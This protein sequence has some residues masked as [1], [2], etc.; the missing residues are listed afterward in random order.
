MFAC[1][2]PF[3]FMKESWPSGRQEKVGSRTKHETSF[4][5][6]FLAL[7]TSLEIHGSRLDTENR[8]LFEGNLANLRKQII[9]LAAE[10][11]TFD[12][13]L[14]LDEGTAMKK[15]TSWMENIQRI[16]AVMS[17][18]KLKN[19]PL[20][21]E[22]KTWTQALEDIRQ[23]IVPLI[24]DWQAHKKINPVLTAAV[25]E[26]RQRFIP[27]VEQNLVQEKEH[28]VHFAKQ[29][30][31]GFWKQALLAGAL[32]LGGV[33]RNTDPHPRTAA[34]RDGGSEKPHSGTESL[35]EGNEQRQRQDPQREFLRRPRGRAGEPE[36]GDSGDRPGELREARTFGRI[37]LYQGH[38]INTSLWV[39]SYQHRQPEQV[40]GRVTSSTVE[41]NLTD[42]AGAYTVS[43]N[44]EASVQL[45]A[46]QVDENEEVVLPTPPGYAVQP[47]SIRVNGNYFDRSLAELNGSA[48]RFHQTGN[49]QIEYRVVK[50]QGLHLRVE[51]TRYQRVLRTDYDEARMSNLRYPDVSSED[52]IAQVMGRMTYVV[53]SELQ[54]LLNRLPGTTEEKVGAVGVGDCDMLSSYAANL[55]QDSGRTGVM[56]TGY[57]AQGEY[58]Q[59]QA[60]AMLYLSE[61]NGDMRSVETTASTR[62]QYI[63]LRFLP[64]DRTRLENLVANFP[65]SAERVARLEGYEQFRATLQSILR[66]PHYDQFKSRGSAAGV[67]EEMRRNM[68]GLFQ[69]AEIKRQHQDNYAPRIL[70]EKYQFHLLGSLYMLVAITL[71]ALATKGRYDKY[72]RRLNE[73]AWDERRNVLQGW[74]DKYVE[75]SG[76]GKSGNTPDEEAKLAQSLQ[77]SFSDLK[78]DGMDEPTAEMITKMS[79][80]ARA[81]SIAFLLL[82]SETDQAKMR[83]HTLDVMHWYGQKERRPEWEQFLATQ[84]A[85]GFSREVLFKELRAQ[86]YKSKDREPWE[87]TK[88]AEAERLVKLGSEVATRIVKEEIGKGR[89]DI[90]QLLATLNLRPE[91][92]HTDSPSVEK[93]VPFRTP[94]TAELRAY[95]PGDDVRGINWKVFAK[96]RQLVTVRGTQEVKP[97]KIAQRFHLHLELTKLDEDQ[98]KKFVAFLLYTAHRPEQTHVASLRLYDHGKEVKAFSGTEVSY[99]TSRRTDLNKPAPLQG[100]LE[101]LQVMSMDA[102]V[103]P[104]EVPEDGT[105]TSYWEVHQAAEKEDLVAPIKRK[106]DLPPDGF[107]L[108]FGMRSTWENDML[109]ASAVRFSQKPGTKPV[110]KPT[111]ETWF[112][113]LLEKLTA[114]AEA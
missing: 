96:T 110:E 10:L 91:A 38:R 111:S 19:I 43:E 69:P 8:R 21:D 89:V 37:T 6:S 68:E 5:T 47:G 107:S 82:L 9:F 31:A 55:L 64:E 17:I 7:K 113:R 46:R 44:P 65:A 22:M 24:W 102:H 104:P 27:Q 106:M 76:S 60:H 25:N 41:G 15:V 28:E 86:M 57:V 97:E 92:G 87:R 49:V 23:S 52:T 36:M 42:V 67:G 32:A 105:A 56:A 26:T 99:L 80:E 51:G 112:A 53:S 12:G 79:A 11:P 30:R 66:N 98:I 39:T 88:T 100:F 62:A 75:T 16:Q 90:S 85:G 83:E 63:N 72:A 4:E 20:P 61:T 3:I 29:Q 103:F 84:E 50:A 101:M 77:R 58:I 54:G 74:L 45:V 33:D 94:E 13:S 2:T 78:I 73:G 93:A 81:T 109:G 34:T 108:M 18:A 48:L 114:R 14:A 71:S 1:Y 35:R 70:V 59:S 95:Q 40:D